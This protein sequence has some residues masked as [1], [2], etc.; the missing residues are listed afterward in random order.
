[1]L[2]PP[3][4]IARLRCSREK[5]PIEYHAL[6]GG[7]PFTVASGPDDEDDRA[8]SIRH[9]GRLPAHAVHLLAQDGHVANY[10]FMEELPR[11]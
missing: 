10:E 6:W 7:Y 9:R 11:V 8:V 3:V 1:M 4:S 5:Q 2:P